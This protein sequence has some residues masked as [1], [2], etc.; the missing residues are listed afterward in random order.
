MQ[1]RIEIII[2]IRK[3]SIFK[4]TLQKV[5]IMSI[6]LSIIKMCSQK[7]WVVM[8]PSFMHAKLNLKLDKTLIHRNFPLYCWH[9]IIYIFGCVCILQCTCKLNQV[10][11]HILLHDHCDKALLTVPYCDLDL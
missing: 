2:K 9:I 11:S 1:S 10:W 8:L 5:L 4:V 3:V 6:L 7:C